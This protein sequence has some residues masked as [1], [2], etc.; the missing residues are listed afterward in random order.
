MWISSP[1]FMM[2]SFI[3][4]LPIKGHTLATFFYHSD[5]CGLAS[6]SPCLRDSFKSFP[7]LESGWDL[8]KHSLAYAPPIPLP[9]NFH[10]TQ[11]QRMISMIWSVLLWPQATSSFSSCAT[12]H[13]LCVLNHMDLLSVLFIQWSSNTSFPPS[14]RHPPTSLPLQVLLTLRVCQMFFQKAHLTF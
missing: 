3:S 11:G 14:A 2:D 9:V 8:E 13:C 4:S 5:S 12:C 7:S 10:S 6:H 1:K